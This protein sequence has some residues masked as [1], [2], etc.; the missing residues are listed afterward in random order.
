MSTA[1]GGRT[2][3]AAASRARSSGE[4]GTAG[5]AGQ[6]PELVSEHQDLQVLDAVSSAD[7][8]QQAGEHAGGQREQEQHRSIVEAAWR[9]R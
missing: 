9:T 1:A 8:E 6:Y 5:L 4:P 7:E 2:R 3:L